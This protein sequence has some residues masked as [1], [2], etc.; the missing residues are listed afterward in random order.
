VTAK[1]VSRSPLLV[2]AFVVLAVL[3]ASFTP[4][5]AYTTS[6]ACFGL[7]HVVVELRYVDARF[8]RRMPSALWWASA[9]VIGVIVLLRGLRLAGVLIDGAVAIELG[10]VAALLAAGAIL[11]R[12]HPV[13]GGVG[14]VAAVVVA[15]GVVVGPIETLLALAVLHNL[16]PLGF[17]VER[18]PAGTRLSTLGLGALI[19]I[20]APLLVGSGVPAALPATIVDVDARFF[21]ARPLAEHLGVYVWPALVTDARAVSL[22]SAAVCAQLLHYGAVLWWLPR[23]LDDGDRP[24]L[25]W[26]RWPVLVGALVVVGGGLTIHFAVDFVGAR[27]A[28][29]LPAAVHAWLELP[30]LLLAFSRPTATPLATSS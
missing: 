4:L 7:A 8:G 14:V 28:Y 17:V 12:S 27:A 1:T 30:L 19:F 20:G 21:S 2:A 24:A 5:L 16:T 22:F 9:A 13:V 25:P 11:A 29:S 6:L 15:V 26:P 23:T 3:W 10:L 18:A